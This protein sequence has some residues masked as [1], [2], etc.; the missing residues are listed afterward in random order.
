MF[1]KNFVDKI[2]THILRPKIIFLETITV[3]GKMW[4]NKA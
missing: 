3:C 4:K 2:K 1:Q